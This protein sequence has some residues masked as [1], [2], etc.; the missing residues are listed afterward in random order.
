MK[1]DFCINFRKHDFII[2]TL[3][4]FFPLI[5]TVLFKTNICIDL[6]VSVLLYPK[7]AQE[8]KK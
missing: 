6:S 5:F 2:V 4:I 8:Y 1:G 3:V 7:L